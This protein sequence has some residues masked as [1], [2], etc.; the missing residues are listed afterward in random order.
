MQ[1]ERFSEVFRDYDGAFL[2]KPVSGRASL[3]I[4]YVQTVEGLS[5]AIANIHRI[6]HDTALIETY[7]PGREFCVAVCGYVIYANQTFSRLK[8]PFTFSVI[9][10]VLEPGEFIFTSMDKKPITEQRSHL[11][12]DQEPELKQELMQIAQRIYQDFCMRQAARC[13]FYNLQPILEK[14]RMRLKRLYWCPPKIHLDANTRKT[15]SLLKAEEIFQPNLPNYVL[16]KI[17]PLH[18]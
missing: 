2:V 8:H 12:D 11:L 16:L 1:S 3:N 5:E 15:I 10:R 6:T 7:L 18:T 9:E 14:C 13:S 17:N 4:H